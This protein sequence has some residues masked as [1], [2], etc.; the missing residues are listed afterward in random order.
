MN[1]KVVLESKRPRSRIGENAR[2]KVLSDERQRRCERCE[3][4]ASSLEAGARHKGG[5][6]RRTK[7][8][9]KTLK[10]QHQRDD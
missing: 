8:R 2:E 5:Q 1:S 9:E 3:A 4:T 10:A 6:R 7:Q